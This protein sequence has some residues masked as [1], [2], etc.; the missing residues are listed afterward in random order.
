M[1]R[2]LSRM[3]REPPSMT[4]G[5][6]DRTFWAWK[7]TDF[8]GPRFQEALYALTWFHLHWSSDN[9]YADNPRVLDWIVAGIHNWRQMQ[10]GDGSFDEAYP[11]E[12][13]LAATAFTG[14]YL[15]EAVQLLN[16]RLP[17]AERVD[18]LAALGRAG[19]WLCRNDEHHG[20]LSNH[21]AAAA[22]ALAVIAR[23]TGED[24]FDKR[25]GHFIGRILSHQSNE[26]WFEE[27]GG[28]DFGY[29][30]HGLFYL[31]RIWTLTGDASLLERLQHSISFLKHF[32]HPNGT[33]GGE[34]GSRNTNFYF[35]AGF[36]MLAAVSVDA[37]AI[38]EF[39]RSSVAA[40]KAVGLQMMD[41]Y[42]LCPMLNNYLFAAQ[43]AGELGE[44]PSLPFAEPG[45]HWFPHAG[46]LVH[47]TTNYQAVFAPSKGGV[48][49]IY[50]KRARELAYSDC[51][52]WLEMPD[53]TK[54]SSQSFSLDNPV[55]HTSCGVAVTVSFATIKQRV[56]TPWLF[57]AFRLFTLTIGR[58]KILAAKIKSLLVKVLVSGRRIIDLSLVRT[59]TFADDEVVI[60]DVIEAGPTAKRN[61]ALHIGSKFSTIHMG[62]SRYFQPD[63]LEPDLVNGKEAFNRT[64]IWR[65]Q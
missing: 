64:F 48:L 63:D 29:Q 5:S 12:R 58:H 43:S 47:S 10:H 50:D 9:P 38:A 19:D 24:R 25:A 1:P 32:I 49:K 37:A 40:Q 55:D 39:M 33:L 34:Y 61:L 41:A 65:A 16:D 21:L 20:I 18:T 15:G 60:D 44:P 62:S 13:S 46:L 28:A 26:G 6:F 51:G 56:M 35:P 7:F 36:E 4:Y 23:L 54:A 17:A 3:D 31:A 22:A 8:A 2:L 59:I 14:F 53:G 30:T 45:H 11:F 42:N 52:Y 27:Y 57:I